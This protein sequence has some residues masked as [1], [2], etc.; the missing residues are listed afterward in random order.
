VVVMLTNTEKELL[1]SFNLT[2]SQKA[3]VWQAWLEND[4]GV[5]LCAE[6]AQAKGRR[7]GNTGAG[8]LL[9]M[10]R[11]G[12][13]RITADE[14]RRTVTGWKFQRGTHGGSYVRDP[15]GTDPLPAGYV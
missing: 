15:K 11:G 10:I 6:R 8:L 5:E 13:H 2:P 4:D 12:E 14:T 3:E 7:N 9:H 1:Q